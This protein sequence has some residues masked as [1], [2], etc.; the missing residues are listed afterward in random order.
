MEIY[1]GENNVIKAYSLDTRATRTVKGSYDGS[2][3][4]G[5]AYD[6][7]N[8]KLYYSLKE[9][10]LRM[11]LDGSNEAIVFSSFSCKFL[12]CQD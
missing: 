3:V 10:I 11:D 9:L 1:F 12:P 7:K 4:L 8:G 2:A 6:S 5:I